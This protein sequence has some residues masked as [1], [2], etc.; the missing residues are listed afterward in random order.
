MERENY[1]KRGESEFILAEESPFRFFDRSRQKCYYKDRFV[2]VKIIDGKEYKHEDVVITPYINDLSEVPYDEILPNG[3]GDATYTLSNGEQVFL[4]RDIYDIP[5]FISVEFSYEYIPFG[6]I[7]IDLNKYTIKAIDKSTPSGEWKCE[8]STNPTA[9]IFQHLCKHYGIEYNTHSL[10]SDA[11]GY[12]GSDINSIQFRKCILEWGYNNRMFIIFSLKD[13]VTM[14]VRK[15]RLKDEYHED[16]KGRKVLNYLCPVSSL[17]KFCE[18]E[19]MLKQI[20]NFDVFER[21]LM[22]NEIAKCYVD[23][24][25]YVIAQ[26][27][28]QNKHKYNNYYDTCKQ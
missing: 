21:P 15:F 5:P 28:H 24:M 19:P 14:D 3:E 4:E 8:Y 1:I 13:L 20:L 26:Q 23:A 6:H 27:K 7:F 2:D 11:A 25:N 18:N 9:N 22:D 16:R 17:R 12:E 10:Y